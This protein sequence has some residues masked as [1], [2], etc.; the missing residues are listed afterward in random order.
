MEVDLQAVE[1]VA[2]FRKWKKVDD[3]L[4]QGKESY[5]R[6]LLPFRWK[7]IDASISWFEN[8]LMYFR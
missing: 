7:Y 2:M 3:E 5:E 4:E 6:A 8:I 1:Y